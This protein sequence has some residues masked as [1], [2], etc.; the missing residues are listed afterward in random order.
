MIARLVIAVLL[1]ASC[2]QAYG[3]YSIMPEVSDSQL[4]EASTKLPTHARFELMDDNISITYDG[5]CKDCQVNL[6]EAAV[7]SC[8]PKKC[9]SSPR[10]A[11]LDDFILGV[12]A[13]SQDSKLVNGL[14][15]SSSKVLRYSG[16][17]IK[18]FRSL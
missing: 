5:Y 6:K 4:T 16:N 13:K 7:Q 1:A 11:D 18:V 8:T 2:C 12:L 10:V 14:K 3:L 15:V 17:W 9:S